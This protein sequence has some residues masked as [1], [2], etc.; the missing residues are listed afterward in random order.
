[1]NVLGAIEGEVAA[2]PETAV[3]SDWIPDSVRTGEVSEIEPLLPGR[4]DPRGRKLLL[5]EESCG[6]WTLFLTGECEA[7][8]SVS[9]ARREGLTPRPSFSVLEGD[10]DI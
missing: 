5:A 4:D 9:D 6:E 10:P 3:E 1:M 8:E 2:D 7:V